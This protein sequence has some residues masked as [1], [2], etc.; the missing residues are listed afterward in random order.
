MVCLL[1]LFKKKIDWRECCIAR[2]TIDYS[3]VNPLAFKALKQGFKAMIMNWKK[4]FEVQELPLGCVLIVPIKRTDLNQGKIV[5]G[6]ELQ[7]LQT[8]GC[9]ISFEKVRDC[10]AEDFNSEVVK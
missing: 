1:G 3:H 10:V 7:T 4:D 8:V 9:N 2:I 5:R 6:M